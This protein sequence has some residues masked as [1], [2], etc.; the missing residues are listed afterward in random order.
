MKIEPNQYLPERLVANQNQRRLQAADERPAERRV[1]KILAAGD[2]DV[3]QVDIRQQWIA[4]VD[5]ADAPDADRLPAGQR[6]SDRWVH[7]HV[8][9]VRQQGR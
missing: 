1:P 3:L 8:R 4:G 6:G 2:V 9:A 5:R 7:H